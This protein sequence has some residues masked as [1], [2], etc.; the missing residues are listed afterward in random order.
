MASPRSTYGFQACHVCFCLLTTCLLGEN[1]FFVNICQYRFFFNTTGRGT[2]I[3]AQKLSK[4]VLRSHLNPIGD[5]NDNQQLSIF[6]LT[7]PAALRM[8]ILDAYDSTFPVIEPVYLVWG[9]M[10]LL[11]VRGVVAMLPE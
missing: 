8:D 6:C 3:H 1:T 4:F 7:C 2:Q 5:Q 9:S 10:M 11:I